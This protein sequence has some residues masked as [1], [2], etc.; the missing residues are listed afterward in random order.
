MCILS[1]NPKV[2]VDSLFAVCDGNCSSDLYG[3]AAVWF[4][5]GNKAVKDLD[6][7]QLRCLC[8]HLWQHSDIM[9]A[10]WI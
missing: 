8:F 4:Q 5:L 9:M 10:A 6:L 7:R 1:Q 2:T 3:K